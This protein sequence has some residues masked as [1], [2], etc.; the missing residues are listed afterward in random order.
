MSASF[1]ING[2]EPPAP[3]KVTVNVQDLSSGSSGRNADGEM[4]I[5]F[6]ASKRKIECEWPSLTSSEMSSLMSLMSAT[7]FPVTYIDPETG[8]S[9]T[10][11]C[12]KGDR[13]APVYWIIGGVV[14]WEGLKVNF[15]EV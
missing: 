5:D 6:V 2:S 10:I 12:Y 3:K 15:I 7:T 9:K 11:T 8:A 4:M 1:L 14:R 13:S